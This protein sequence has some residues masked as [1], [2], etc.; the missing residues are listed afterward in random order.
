MLSGKFSTHNHIS[1]QGPD[2]GAEQ[3]GPQRDLNTVPDCDVGLCIQDVIYY[4]R[5]IYPYNL[6]K[7]SQ[8]NNAK[9]KKYHHSYSNRDNHEGNL[10]SKSYLF[11]F[12]RSRFP[13]NRCI[14]PSLQH[15]IVEDK[16]KH[17]RCDQDNG[18]HACDI[19]IAFTGNRQICVRREE[20]DPPPQDR[21]VT[22]FGNG[23]YKDQKPCFQKAGGTQRYCNGTDDPEF[24]STHVAGSLFQAGV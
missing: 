16:D 21:L 2:N 6:D 19:E 15:V 12:N 11:W 10:D 4:E 23:H 5:I 3:A 17:T 14:T 7:G 13:H 8:Y 20:V 9:A 1:Q 18:K 24:R 22:E